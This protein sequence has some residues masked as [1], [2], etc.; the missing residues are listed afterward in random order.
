MF[1]SHPGRLINLKEEEVTGNLRVMEGK[2]HP[3]RYFFDQ[4]NYRELFLICRCALQSSVQLDVQGGVSL[5]DALERKRVAEEI[6]LRAEDMML[7]FYPDWLNEEAAND[8][9]S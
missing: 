8:V 7:L 3:S 4:F 9:A 1:N 5:R 6:E 2:E